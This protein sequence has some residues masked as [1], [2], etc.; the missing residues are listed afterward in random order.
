MPRKGLTSLSD[1]SDTTTE[2]NRIEFVVRQLLNRVATATLVIVRGVD[3]DTVDVQ[4]MVAQ[5]DGAGNA[6][7]HGTINSVPFFSPRAGTNALV[8][9]P[10]V[11]DIGLAIFCHNDVS[12]AKKTKAPATPGSRRRFDWA[13]ALYLGG[14]L[15]PEPTQFIRLDPDGVTIT[16]ASGKPVAITGTP[17]Q[18]TGAIDSDTA[19][20]VNGTKVVGPQQATI[21]APSG[22]STV[23]SAARTTL[24]SILTALKAHGLIAS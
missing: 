9:T 18:V 2:F 24:G 4:P 5:L 16:A 23:D 15:G 10:V 17:L 22:G 14:F 7:E 20:R 6:V 19:L 12:S 13:D 8:M 3:T 21:A 1:F 11:G